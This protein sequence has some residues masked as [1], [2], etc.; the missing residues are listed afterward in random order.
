MPRAKRKIVEEVEDEDIEDEEDEVEEAPKPKRRGRPA[1]KAAAPTPRK[2]R[3]RAKVKAV[4]DEDEDLED[5]DEDED[6]EED[7]EETPKK[8]RSKSKGTAAKRDYAEVGAIWDTLDEPLST[9]VSYD[10]EECKPLRAGSSKQGQLL[11]YM[12]TGARKK[13]GATIKQVI[14]H[15]EDLEE[16]KYEGK[17][18]SMVKWWV[19][20]GYLLAE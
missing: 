19:D 20:N 1:K 18:E 8:K 5:E 3:G 13:R 6:E 4:E 15:I 9:R 14:A 2:G 16:G 10:E 11:E 7:E 12:T 17:G